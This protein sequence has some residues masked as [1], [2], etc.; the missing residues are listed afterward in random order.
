M[1]TNIDLVHHVNFDN[2]EATK[3]CGLHVSSCP[4]NIQNFHL[5][6]PNFEMLGNMSLVSN[7]TIVE[8]RNYII[9]VDKFGVPHGLGQSWIV[10][11][12]FL[13]FILYK[14]IFLFM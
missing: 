13:L 4:I 8:L 11:Q 10:L 5:Y 2:L 14:F 12:P 9:S 6:C 3:R 1:T 7:F